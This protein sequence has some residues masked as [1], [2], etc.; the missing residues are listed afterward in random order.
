[1]EIALAIAIAPEASKPPS[2]EKLS[3]PIVCF[4]YC[5][6]IASLFVRGGEWGVGNVYNRPGKL[7]TLKLL[8]TKST[9]PE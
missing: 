2:L 6:P 5:R 4:C 8:I 7:V 3:T 9:C 1:M